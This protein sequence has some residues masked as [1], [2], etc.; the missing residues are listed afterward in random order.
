MGALAL[1]LPLD[2]GVRNAKAAQI[3]A[4]A[5]EAEWRRRRE[6]LGGIAF[7][8]QRAYASLNE[9]TRR[10]AAVRDGERAAKAWLTAVA[11]N[12]ATGLAETRD[13]TD[14]VVQSFQFRIRALQTIFD[15]NVAAATLTRATGAEVAIPKKPPAAEVVGAAP[16]RPR[17]TSTMPSPDRAHGSLTSGPATTTASPST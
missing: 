9:A 15:L 14:A 6:A 17:V 4:E 10:L 13:F 16:D 3:E 8:V 11:A 7:E 5:E 2:L 1:R 12:F